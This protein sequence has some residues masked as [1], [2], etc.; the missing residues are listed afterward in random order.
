[1]L[2]DAGQEL[3]ISIYSSIALA[4][5]LLLPFSHYLMQGHLKSDFFRYLRVLYEHL[6]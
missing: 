4:F 3:R 2:S 1:M 5:L 6:Y